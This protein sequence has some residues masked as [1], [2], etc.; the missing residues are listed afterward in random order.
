[1][2]ALLDYVEVGAEDLDLMRTVGDIAQQGAAP[3]EARALGHVRA[4]LGVHR[5][6]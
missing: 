5:P 4:A 1:M 2:D 6:R 3:I